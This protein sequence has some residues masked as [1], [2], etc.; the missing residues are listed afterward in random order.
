M[1]LRVAFNDSFTGLIYSA[2]KTNARRPQSTSCRL[3]KESCKPAK[4][5]GK[6]SRPLAGVQISRIRAHR[7]PTLS[8]STFF[9]AATDAGAVT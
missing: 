1:K 6:A 7:L 9:N 4:Q 5:E 8:S 3:K 2:G